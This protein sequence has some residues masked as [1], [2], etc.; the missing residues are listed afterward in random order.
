MRNY[1]SHDVNARNDAKL[2]KVLMRLGQAGKGVYWDLVEM[3][4]EQDGYLM[5]SDCESYAFALRTDCDLINSLISDFG[6]FESDGE[7]FWSESALRR[8]EHR[9][10]KSIKAK[11]SAEKRWHTSE[12]NA[13]AMRTHSDGNAIKERKERKERKVNKPV[14]DTAVPAENLK[15]SVADNRV[16]VAETTAKFKAWEGWAAKEAPQVLKL[17]SPITATE[18]EKLD[19]DL[20]RAVVKD[21]ALAMHNHA[22]LLKKYTS[23]NLT[24]RQWA[25]N[26]TVGT[27]N[28][29]QYGPAPTPENTKQKLTNTTTPIL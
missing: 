26:R 7:R 5:H 2:I 20:G 12:R 14:V 27:G 24:M 1:F 23:A 13:N 4:H 10:G 9:N 28:R 17:K 29:S 22:Q 6:L 8:I 19:T 18:L 11:E 16:T 25:K 3:L 15:V 21:I